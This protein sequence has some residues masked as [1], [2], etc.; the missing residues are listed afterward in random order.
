MS[1][2]SRRGVCGT[3]ERTL[4]A[5]LGVQVNLLRLRNLLENLLY[6]L[7]VVVADIAAGHALGNCSSRR[8]WTNLGVSSRW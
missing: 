3:R 2:V 6:D 4:E 5:L 8:S 1:A 7:T